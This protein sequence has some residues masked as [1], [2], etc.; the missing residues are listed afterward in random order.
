MMADT[1]SYGSEDVRRY[2]IYLVEIPERKLNFLVKLENGE[3][4]VNSYGAVT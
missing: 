2:L 3:K 1:N 4:M